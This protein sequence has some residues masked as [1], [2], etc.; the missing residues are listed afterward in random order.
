MFVCFVRRV[1]VMRVT[2]SMRTGLGMQRIGMRVSIVRVFGGVFR[3]VLLTFMIVSVVWHRID[4][5]NN[6]QNNAREH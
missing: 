5:G 6:Q 2:G 1:V 4:P 3:T